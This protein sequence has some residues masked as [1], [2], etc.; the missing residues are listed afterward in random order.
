MAISTITAPRTTS[1]ARE[2]PAGPQVSVLAFNIGELYYNRRFLAASAL[3]FPDPT[4]AK[5]RKMKP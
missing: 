4:A 5:Y 3:Y 1:T 2:R